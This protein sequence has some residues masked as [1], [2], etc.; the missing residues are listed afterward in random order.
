MFKS[1]LFICIS[2]FLL[3]SCNTRYYNNNLHKI[4]TDTIKI[5]PEYHFNKSDLP[6][7][8]LSETGREMVLVK[9]EKLHYTWFDAT[10]ENGDPFDYKRNLHG[11]GNQLLT[12]GEDFPHLNKKGV[13]DERELRKTKTITA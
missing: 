3:N 9:T 8:A 2:A 12:N 5:F 6:S 7:P 13:H 1:G 11:K 10:V 4:H